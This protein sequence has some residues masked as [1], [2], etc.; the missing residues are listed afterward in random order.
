M[1]AIMEEI[2]L[3]RKLDQTNLPQDL[4]RKEFDVL[5]VVF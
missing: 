1:V 5:K 2:F 3:D 4:K